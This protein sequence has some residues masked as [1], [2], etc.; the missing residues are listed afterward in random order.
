MTVVKWHGGNDSNSCS[1]LMFIS[2]W[3]PCN[4]QSGALR[5]GVVEPHRGGATQGLRPTVALTESD[6]APGLASSV[7]TGLYKLQALVH[8]I[9]PSTTAVFSYAIGSKKTVS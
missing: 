6:H 3:F 2:L 5:V 4:I 7:T 8:D 9:L 1:H